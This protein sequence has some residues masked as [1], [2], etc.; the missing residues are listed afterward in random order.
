MAIVDQ[1]GRPIVIA[2]L[3][4]EIAT[5]QV[6]GVRQVWQ[7]SIALGLTPAGL[8]NVLRSAAEGDHDSYLT[9]AEEMEERDPHYAAVLAN[10]KQAVSGLQ[11]T[12]EAVDESA[13]AMRH[14]ELLEAL[15]AMPAFEAML[16][17]QLDALGKGYSVNEIIWDTSE[18]Q[19]MPKAFEHRDPR[20]FQFDRASQ[21][22]LHLRDAA[23][24][25]DGVPLAPYKFLA[26][27]PRIKTGLPIRGGLARVVAFAWICKAYALKDWVAFAE[28][29]G[30]PLRI[31]R[32]GA[33]ANDD[34]IRVLK[35]AVA[36][37]GTDAAAV[38]P[39]SMKI[40]F[41]EVSKTGGGADVFE[42]LCAYI[43][44]QIS[45]AVLGQT[46]TTESGGGS[47]LAQ[48][49]VHNEV[50][51]DIQKKDAKQL[52]ATI[53]AMLVRPIID[54][55]FGP[56]KTY[57]RICLNVPEPED[58]AGLVTALKE[59]V[60]LGLRVEQ[61]VIRDK[62]GLPEPADDA[63]LLSAPARRERASGSEP[64]DDDADPAAPP[65][66]ARNAATKPAPPTTSDEQASR[67]VREGDP[68][69]GALVAP[70]E[71]ML[72][73]SNSFEEFR[74]KLL[75]AYTDLDD[76]ALAELLTQGLTAA[77]LAGR[78]ELLLGV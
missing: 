77:H 69:V 39:E 43:D 21:R 13:P 75:D 59:L 6:T 46:M 20:W 76:K 17:E 38:L 64:P 15:V 10:R 60:P 30:M 34:D 40:E 55:N 53:N 25:T 37:I 52:A 78:Y 19:W 16:E 23:N 66:K 11:V 61:S 18:R 14:T 73:A 12:V 8:A 28:V 67:M 24:L 2:D 63:E 45:K 44:R 50:R 4:R 41:Q 31:G 48:A 7:S 1:F 68:V 57:P 26:H 70:I 5:P 74:E 71:Q 65:A 3:K 29:F 36:N 56:Q 47:G 62:F 32:Y 42:R 9:L 51:Q 58:L 49:K 35:M 27:L 22:E 54:L 72:A 33:T